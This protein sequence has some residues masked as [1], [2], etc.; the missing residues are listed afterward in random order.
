MGQVPRL[1]LQTELVLRAMLAEPG[2][3][4][5]GLELRD[6]TGLRSGTIYPIIARLEHAGWLAGSWE[7]PGEHV[8]A[9]RPRRRYYRLTG[10][11]AELARE[12]IARADQSRKRPGLGALRP[13]VSG[14]WS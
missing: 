11:G 13:G 12:A 3:Q 7:D 14:A 1:T 5:Y 9:G 4:R 8:A 6:E 10:E 2:A